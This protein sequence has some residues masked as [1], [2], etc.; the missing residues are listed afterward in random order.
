MKTRPVSEKILRLFHTEE[1]VKKVKDLSEK[2][3]GY[4]DYGDTPAFRGMYDVTR[5]VV[6]AAVKAV[7]LV[8]KGEVNQSFNMVGGLHHAFK[9]RAEGFCVFNDVAVAITYT[10]QKLNMK[11]I[12]YVDIDAHHGNGV[13]YSFYDDPRVWIVDIHQSGKTLYPGTGFEDEKGEGK[14]Y[15]TKLNFP[16]EPF[17]TD[18]DL[19]DAVD[20]AVE[21]GRKAKPNI[22]LMQAG[23][24]CVEGDPITSLRFSLKGHLEAVKKFYD[25]SCDVCS[26]KMIIFGGGGYNYENCTKAWINILK[27][28]V[29]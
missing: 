6:Y 3:Y 10:L 4:L 13:F 22:V 12:L 2:G 25:L 20:K 15:G 8:S 19:L 26:G 21:F 28:L 5:H 17:A 29:E 16:L 7:E 23:V 24:D 11:R 14:A 18:K 1:Y 27:L 9:D